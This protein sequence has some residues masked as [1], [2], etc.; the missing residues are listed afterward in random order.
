MAGRGRPGEEDSGSNAGSRDGRRGG[1]S[2]ASVLGNAGFVGS[3]RPS[4]MGSCCSDARLLSV[5]RV[6]VSRCSKSEAEVCEGPRRG[7]GA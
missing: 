6:D 2:F 1:A 4:M 3:G 7:A 5:C